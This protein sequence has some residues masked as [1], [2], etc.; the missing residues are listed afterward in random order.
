MTDRCIRCGFIIATDHQRC[1]VAAANGQPWLCIA[2][3]D[4]SLFDVPV[5]GKILRVKSGCDVNPVPILE[6]P[7]E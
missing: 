7:Y 5:G 3:T 1:T 6:D 4:K 2:T